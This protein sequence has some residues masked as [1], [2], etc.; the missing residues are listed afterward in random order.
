M[1]LDFFKLDL[2]DSENLQVIQQKDSVWD[3]WLI[4]QTKLKKTRKNPPTRTAAVFN[5]VKCDYMVCLIFLMCHVYKIK[6]M[7][8]WF[9]RLNGC[10]VIHQ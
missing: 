6:L 4:T 2:R 10:K 8:S 5:Q 1:G 7:F 3:V 9:L